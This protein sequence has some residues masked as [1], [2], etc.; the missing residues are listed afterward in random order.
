MIRPHPARRSRG[1]LRP[2][3]T[4][5]ELLVVI[6][7]IGILMAIILPAVQGAREAGRRVTCV[8]NLYQMGLAANRFNEARRYVP[9][10]RNAVGSSNYSWPV[11]LMPYMERKDIWTAISSAPLASPP[12][13]SALACPSSPPADQVSPWLAY[14]G[15]VGVGTNLSNGRFTGVMLD[16]N[17]SSGATSG[18]VSM[19]D[20][21]G[22]DGTSMTM[23]LSEMSGPLIA[24]QGYWNLTFASGT[25]VTWTGA[26]STQPGAFG[27]ASTTLPLNG[28]IIS[29]TALGGSGVC[30]ASNMPSSQHPGG[31]VAAFCDGRTTFLKDNLQSYTYAQL[32]SWNHGTA[33]TGG[34]IT[35]ATYS[36]TNWAA[37]YPLLQE[38]DY[39]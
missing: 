10:W 6:A 22:N 39:Q 27:I 36:N 2:G 16:T 4:L 14:A 8:S 7:I 18:R 5:V 34:A 30:G 29:N 20:V 28:K 35:N 26:P 32:M 11:M 24:T 1:L 31:A 9:G 25:A 23:M 15:S 38:K 33:A 12:Y 21:A 17:V 19:D 3:F 13:I 37:N